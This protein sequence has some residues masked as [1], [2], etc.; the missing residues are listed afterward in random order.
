MHTP[1]L[2]A[3]MPT[4]EVI[5]LTPFLPG[6]VRPAA[7]HYPQRTQGALGAGPDHAGLGY[8]V[9]ERTTRQRSYQNFGNETRFKPFLPQ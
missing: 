8:K 9:S 6:Q 4:A 5:K 2:T 7:L 3:M 1:P